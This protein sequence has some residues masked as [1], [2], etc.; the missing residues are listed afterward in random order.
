MRV[1]SLRRSFGPDY[2][3]VQNEIYRYL[4]EQKFFRREPLEAK[5]SWRRTSS[6]L[7]LASL[8]VWALL[9]SAVEYAGAIALGI[10]ALGFAAAV[11]SNYEIG[12]AHV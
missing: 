12:R 4:V 6:G 10:F 9:R 1:N 11:L 5:I 2:V 7:A 3:A 8:L